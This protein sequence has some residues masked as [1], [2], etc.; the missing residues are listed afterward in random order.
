MNKARHASR[1]PSSLGLGAEM[2]SLHRLPTSLPRAGAQ[3]ALPPTSCPAPGAQGRLPLSSSGWHGQL[4][5]AHSHPAAQLA[6]SAFLPTANCQECSR[7][8]PAK[9]GPAVPSGPDPP[10]SQRSQGYALDLSLPVCHPAVGLKPGVGGRG[11]SSSQ[12]GR[13]RNNRNLVSNSGGSLR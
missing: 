12:S 6:F 10:A 7:C 11:S 2:F 5:A 1:S 8:L 13:S 4:W 9:S 3:Q